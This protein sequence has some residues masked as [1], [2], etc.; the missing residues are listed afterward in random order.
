M[1][2]ITIDAQLS[3]FRMVQRVQQQSTL[4]NH[5]RTMSLVSY[6]IEN[7]TL[8]D[9]VRGRIFASFQVMSKFLPQVERYKR[10][11]AKSESVYVFGVPDVQPPIIPN[12]TYV[13]LKP[14]DQLAKEWFL[15]SYGRD[16]YSALATEEQ[17]Q[18][19]D[20]DHLRVFEGIWTFDLALVGIM[21]DWLTSA[22]DARTQLIEERERNYIRQ[23]HLMSNT[24]GRLTTRLA[25]QSLKSAPN[26]AIVNERNEIKTLID[27]TL[28]PAL[29][30]ST[31]NANV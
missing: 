28:A 22:V 30:E 21:N 29:T 27:T 10:I 1:A 20:P 15:I 14:T 9:N 6:E 4:L 8:L 12:I 24:L 13:D 19:S 5:R 17:S 2:N 31:K 16:Y 7:A 25:T 18:L 26:S 3:V 23:I 11:A